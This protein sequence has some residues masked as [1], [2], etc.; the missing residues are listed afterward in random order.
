MYNGLLQLVERATKFRHAFRYTSNVQC[1]C[2]C[3]YTYFIIYMQVQY[4]DYYT[5]TCVYVT[6]CM[7]KWP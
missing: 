1:T 4:D 7:Y 5:Y 2:T 6:L 3:I